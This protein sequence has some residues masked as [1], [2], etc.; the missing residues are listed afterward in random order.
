METKRRAE[1]AAAAAAARAAADQAASAAA[2]SA[3]RPTG[4]A[5]VYGGG[6][7]AGAGPVARPGAAPG[8][9]GRGSVA[10][11]ATVNTAFGGEGTGGSALSPFGG[12]G[13]PFAPVRQGGDRFRETVQAAAEAGDVVVVADV[14]GPLSPLLESLLEQH[15]VVRGASRLLALG[16]TF[17]E[18]SEG[19]RY[20]GEGVGVGVVGDSALARACCMTEGGCS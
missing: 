14:D 3:P 4:M 9:G 2:E 13:A 19:F 11:R 7:A 6:G 15:V 17:V 20:P 18:L 10:G 12:R 5:S 8:P 16:D 1:V